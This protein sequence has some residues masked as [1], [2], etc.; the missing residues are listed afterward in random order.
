[1]P[2]SWPGALPALPLIEVYSETMADAKLRTEMDAGPAK[3]R[4]RYT[5][6]PRRET[7]KLRMTSTQLTAAS[8]N[9]FDAFYVTDTAHGATEFTWANPRAPSSAVTM[10][11]IGVP[12]Y[13]ALSQGVWDVSF[14]VEI[15]P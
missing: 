6:V 11:F 8:P 4:R 9:G 5:S 3:V 15:L 12:T 1:M 13:S 2:V 7:V 14:E 10:R